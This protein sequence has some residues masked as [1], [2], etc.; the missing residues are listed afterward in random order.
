M[1]RKRGQSRPARGAQAADGVNGASDD[2]SNARVDECLL[3]M[4]QVSGSENMRTASEGLSTDDETDEEGRA[5]AE[6]RVTAAPTSRTANR[7][8]GGGNRGGSA[9]RSRGRAH[10]RGGRSTALVNGD[11]A[12]QLQNEADQPQVSIEP[13]PEGL[14]TMAGR[15]RGRSR[16]GRRGRGRRA[17]T[18]A[19][20]ARDGEPDR[21]QPRGRRRGLKRVYAVGS[22][23]SSAK[24]QV[25]F[26]L[27][28]CLLSHMFHTCM[29]TFRLMVT[30]MVIAVLLA[31]FAT[32][33]STRRG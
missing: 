27:V 11:G 10:G 30:Q 24:R 25:L 12:E 32:T 31:G 3:A 18:V 7:S 21:Q 8:R 16:R 26:K 6:R 19:T 33:A 22:D 1:A 4:D 28:L 14:G 15:G 23:T 29:C 13:A 2:S 17:A 9:R 20:A 5:A